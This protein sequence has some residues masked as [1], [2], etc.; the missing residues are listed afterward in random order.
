MLLSPHNYASTVFEF[1]GFT[2]FYVC[3]EMVFYFVFFCCYHKTVTKNNL[4]RK[5]FVLSYT[6][7]S[8]PITEQ[9]RGKNP[10]QGLKCRDHE[11]CLPACF[12]IQPRDRPISVINKETVS[13]HA[14]R[15]V[16]WVLVFV[17]LRQGLFYL[18]LLHT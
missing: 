6:S 1:C 12:L 9:R 13:Q 18:L 3:W 10:K 5:R 8:K 2:K 7:R 17:C 4:E 11:C 16:L 15:P 14:Y